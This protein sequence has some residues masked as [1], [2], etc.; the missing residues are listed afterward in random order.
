M[1]FDFELYL[2]LATLISGVICLIDIFYW[3][4]IRKEK[5]I[6]KQ[7]ILIEY[8]R[9]FFPILLIVLLLRSFLA[10]P[11]RIP[12]GSEKP[13]LLVGDFIVANKFAYGL[14]LPV[15]RTQLVHVGEPKRGDTTLFRPPRNPSIYYIKRIVGVPGDHISY[16]NKVLYINGVEAKQKFLKQVTDKDDNGNVQTQDMMEED[17]MGVKHTIYVRPDRLAEDGSW[18]V[19]P[20]HYFA[21]GDNRDG[22]NDSRY[23]G[24]VPEHNLV[25]KA[26]LIFF[27]W[28]NDDHQVRWDRIGM[29]IH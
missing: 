3:A 26:F 12:S 29:V 5:S 24:F 28:N 10:E 4:P 9:S 2:T 17:L 18:V 11:F 14:R 1:D 23:W 27:S 15:L 21:M 16:I 25:G 13:G 22:S 8:A 20:G 6:T 7:P 19:P